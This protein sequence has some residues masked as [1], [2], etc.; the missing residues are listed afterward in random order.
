LSHLLLHHH[1]YSFPTRRS[2]DLR[3]DRFPKLGPAAESGARGETETASDFPTARS[4]PA[5][6]RSVPNPITSSTRR[7]SGSM[8]SPPATMA[9]SEEHTSELQSRSDLVCRLLL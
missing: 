7:C 9:R 2:S 3:T 5:A 4:I 8:H 6:G 1:L